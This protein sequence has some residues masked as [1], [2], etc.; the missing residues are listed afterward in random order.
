[1]K[2]SSRIHIKKSIPVLF[3]MLLIGVIIAAG[4]TRANVPVIQQSNMPSSIVQ[5]QSIDLTIH[6][7]SDTAV[8]D[9]YI[10]F[11]DGDKIPMTKMEVQNKSQELADWGVILNL[12][13]GEYSYRVVA[14]DRSGNKSLPLEGKITVTP[15][16]PGSE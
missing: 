4:C 13:A 16:N 10:Q 7:A 8:K 12:P 3:T 6:T 1:M 11:G 5:G 15:K 14:E 9:V 2:I